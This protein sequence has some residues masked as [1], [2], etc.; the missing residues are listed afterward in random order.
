VHAPYAELGIR[1]II[2]SPSLSRA[3]LVG[4]LPRRLL[5]RDRDRRAPDNGGDYREAKNARV[6]GVG[7]Q[8]R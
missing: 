5:V 8:G 1:R 7:R 2:P 4:P 6:L 3:T